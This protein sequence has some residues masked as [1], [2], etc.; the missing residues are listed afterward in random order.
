MQLR[1]TTLNLAAIALA[2]PLHAFSQTSSSLAPRSG[3]NSTGRRHLIRLR[4]ELYPI[5]RQGVVIAHKASY[6][7]SVH[8]GYP[9]PQEFR[10]VFDTGSGHL[11]LPCIECETAICRTKG[12][13]NATASASAQAINLDGALVGADDAYDE[14]SIGFGTGQITGRF[15]REQV[16]LGTTVLPGPCVRAQ[17]VAATE[18]SSSPFELFDFDGILGLSLNGLAMAPNFS[19]PSLL[20]ASGGLGRPHFGFFLAQETGEE[21]EIAIGGH[22]E[23]KIREIRVG[24]R[25]L[26]LCTHGSCSGILDTGTSHIGV[27]GPHLASLKQALS[28]AAEPS[29]D[30]LLADAPS[31]EFD[32]H[33]VNVTLRSEDYMR[34]LPLRRRLGRGGEG[35]SESVCTPKIAAINLPAVGPST[36]V[37][38]EVVLQRYYTVYDWSV[39]RVGFGLASRPRLP[40]QAGETAKVRLLKD[41]LK[42][43]VL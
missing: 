27:P 14:A 19:L 39:P 18:M 7:G 22:N 30:C 21:S 28:V 13:Y 26:D 34:P 43:I 20:E 37:F 2:L 36:F 17:F 24:G 41:A 31:L 38:G 10:V 35:A 40:P 23:V 15:F 12:R 1:T 5:K 3:D 33:S 4:R 8:V 25:K 32:L 16:C 42:D 11:V 9:E 6:Y 29:M